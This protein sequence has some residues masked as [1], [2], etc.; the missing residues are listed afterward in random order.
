MQAVAGHEVVHMPASVPAAISTQPDTPTGPNS[1]EGQAAVV[2]L[3]QALGKGHSLLSQFKSKEAITAFS[4]LPSQ[5]YQTAWVLS[6]VGKAH[7]EL[8]NYSQALHFFEWSRAQDPYRVEGLEWH[9]TVLWHM[10][11]EVC[12]P[13]L[14]YFQ[15]KHYVQNARA[16][17]EGFGTLLSVANVR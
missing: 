4:V 7:F 2:R 3:L 11:K 8:V 13:T 1:L 15:H 17:I 14:L 16:T 6:Q 10:K 12:R 5:H 9:S